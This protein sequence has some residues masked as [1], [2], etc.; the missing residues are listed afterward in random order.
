MQLLPDFSTKKQA[1]TDKKLLLEQNFTLQF[2]FL[3]LPGDPINYVTF[4]R[5]SKARNFLKTA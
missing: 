3:D 5:S 1:K 2:Y 4:S